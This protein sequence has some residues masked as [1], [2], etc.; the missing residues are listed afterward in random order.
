MCF[1]T[2]IFI[3]QRLTAYCMFRLLLMLPAIL[4][5]AMI[6][7]AQPGDSSIVLPNRLVVTSLKNPKAHVQLDTTG[8]LS[9]VCVNQ[10]DSVIRQQYRN[11][12]GKLMGYSDSSLILLV[13]NESVTTYNRNGTMETFFYWRSEDS[14]HWH[15]DTLQ[16]SQIHSL[17][18]DKGKY[19]PVIGILQST[20][21]LYILG[22]IAVL[23]TAILT[24]KKYGSMASGNNLILS[25]GA[26]LGA[27]GVSF[28]FYPKIFRVNP[29]IKKRK[30]AKWRL[31]VI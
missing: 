20:S 11:L 23:V 21:Y 14:L 7:L 29:Q 2:A 13:E 18:F 25:T 12:T 24:P 8:M 1:E 28:L 17:R 15:V 9:L 22:N 26:A 30:K 31:E 4:F 6:A 3:E 10:S 5:P 19:K 27:G 16:F